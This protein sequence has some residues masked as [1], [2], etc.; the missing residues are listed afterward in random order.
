MYEITA[1]NFC[2]LRPLYAVQSVL[3]FSSTF[4]FMSKTRNA[5]FLTHGTYDQTYA[6]FLVIFSSHRC[7]SFEVVHMKRSKV[8]AYRVLDLGFLGRIGFWLGLERENTRGFG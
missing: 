8:S 3:P 6:L 1:L 7:Q 5:A 2:H 4:L